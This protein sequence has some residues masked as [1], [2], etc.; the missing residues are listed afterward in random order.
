M[1]LTN[2]EKLLYRQLEHSCALAIRKIERAVSKHYEAVPVLE[3][4]Y[5]GQDYCAVTMSIPAK[6]LK[7]SYKPV[8]KIGMSIYELRKKIGPVYVSYD[9][10]EPCW[11][12]FDKAGF[13]HHGDYVI[14]WKQLR[15]NGI[16]TTP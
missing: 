5:R 13:S 12:E 6:S 9:Y 7:K 15:I 14:C 11:Q 8:A 4:E 2:G 1:I 16:Y 10:R 3:V